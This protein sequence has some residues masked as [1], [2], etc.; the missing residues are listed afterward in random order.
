MPRD[1]AIACA[2]IILECTPSG[3]P[4]LYDELKAHAALA[5]EIVLGGR[6]LCC[7][8]ARRTA[9]PWPFLVVALGCLPGSAGLSPG[10]L[11]VADTSA[12]FIGYGE[13]VLAYRLQPPA[14]IWAEDAAGGFRFWEQHGDVVLLGGGQVI[15]AWSAA[16]D[17]L[18]TVRASPDWNHRVQGQVLEL[19]DDAG[20]KR[21]FPLGEGPR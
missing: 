10:A 15:A 3:L 18:W 1:F 17:K 9:E 12:L 5:D 16:G 13:R 2:D 11:F 4:D 20:G 7:L 6:D 21:S 14:K 19:T 8:T